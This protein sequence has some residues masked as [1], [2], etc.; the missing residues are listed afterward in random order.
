VEEKASETRRRVGR[1]RKVSLSPA[2][3]NV[4]SPPHFV[5]GHQGRNKSKLSEAQTE[6]RARSQAFWPKV[7]RSRINL[8]F[9]AFPLLSPPSPLREIGLSYLKLVNWPDNEGNFFER[10]A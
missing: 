2:R 10:K 8:V 7:E 1:R 3:L 4:G 5:L 9:K 6:K